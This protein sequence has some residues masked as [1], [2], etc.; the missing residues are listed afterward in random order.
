[1]KKIFYILAS[2]IVALGA[3]ACEN[4]AMDNIANTEGDTV[5]FVANIDDTKTDL[6]DKQ[7]IWD[8]DDTIVVEWNGETYEFKN[9][10]SDNNTFSCKAEGLNAI[11]TANIKATYSNNNDGAIDSEAGTAGA[12]LTYEGAFAD[13]MFEVKNAFLTITADKGATIA[14]TASADIF[15]TGKSIELTAIGAE[16]YIAVNPE[17][18]TIALSINGESIKTS[19]ENTLAVKKIYNLG[20]YYKQLDTI[21]KDKRY[22]FTKATEFTPGKWYAVVANNVAATAITG[23]YGYIYTVNPIQV[24]ENISLPASCAFGF[25][26]TDGGYTIKQ[27]DNRYLY[28]TGTY[29]NFNVTTSPTSGQ[30]FSVEINDEKATIVNIAMNKTVQYSAQHVSFGAYST[31]TNVIPTLYELVEVDTNSHLL[32]TS[33]SSLSYTADGGE[34]TIT[35]T[36]YGT[37]EWTAE[38]DQT[39]AQVDYDTTSGEIRVTVSTNDGDAREATITVSYGNTDYEVAVS[40]AAKPSGDTLYFTKVTETPTDWSGTYLIVYE[41]TGI[42]LDGSSTK[43]DAEGNY[44]KVTIAGNQIEATDDVLNLTFTIEKSTTA[45]N[46]YIKSASGYYI[47]NTKNQNKLVY[48]TSTKYNNTLTLSDTDDV[49]VVSAQSHLRFNNATSNGN[50]FRYYKSSSYSAQQAIQFYKLN[51]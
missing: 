22:I 31:V 18:T 8:D 32:G 49:E 10:E 6:L 11:K 51:E 40:Q 35:V 4:D 29:N 12:V 30:V 44:K 14:L 37:P 7:T 25:T 45:D 24:N 3:V 39:W 43:I 1:M 41:T 47:G 28:M 2:A 36:T 23:N 42:A 21:E 27:Y 16:Q 20:N 13:I 48:N 46:Y 38:S 9:S 50:R 5:S 17:T 15:S 33:V 19:Q 34:E 26:S